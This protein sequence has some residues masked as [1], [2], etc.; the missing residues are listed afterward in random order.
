MKSEYYKLHLLFGP[1]FCGTMPMRELFRPNEIGL[2]Q[3]LHRYTLRS[4]RFN[5]VKCTSSFLRFGA[6][7]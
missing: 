5:V 6:T 3:I 7:F 1:N 2:L 4:D